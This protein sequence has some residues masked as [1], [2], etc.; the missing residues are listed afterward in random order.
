MTGRGFTFAK[1][2]TSSS[3]AKGKELKKSDSKNVARIFKAKGKGPNLK[4]KSGS[5]KS[6]GRRCHPERRGG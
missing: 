5:T 3:E 4:G 1:R 6:T 2:T